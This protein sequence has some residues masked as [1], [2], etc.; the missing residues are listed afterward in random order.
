MRGTILYTDV[1]S[2]ITKKNKLGKKKNGINHICEDP[3][4]TKGKLLSLSSDMYCN[5]LTNNAITFSFYKP[6]PLFWM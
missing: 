1:I 6:N 5:L 2:N 3:I 4:H